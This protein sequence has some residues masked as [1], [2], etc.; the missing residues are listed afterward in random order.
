M[1]NEV[2]GWF[3]LNEIEI[4]NDAN[5]STLTLLTV[6]MLFYFIT[7]KLIVAPTQVLLRNEASKYRSSGLN[8]NLV[9]NYKA[10]L[11]SFMEDELGF[12]D[13]KLSLTRLSQH[14]DI[15]KQ[16]ISEILNVHLNTNFQ[17]FVNKY[18]VEAF[19]NCL[20]SNQYNHFALMGIASEVGFN[21]KSS[22]YTSFKKYK[23]VTPT[24][25]KRSIQ[26]AD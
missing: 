22:F 17:D 4:F 19:V 1:L 10:Q 2:L 11:V 23:G 16:Y 14:L 24:E 15:P 13:S 20:K 12:T 21:S 25:F 7:M 3:E 8:P 18:R 6:A 9:E 26:I 5:F